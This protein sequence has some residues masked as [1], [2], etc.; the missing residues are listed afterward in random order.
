MTT[1]ASRCARWAAAVACGAVLALAPGP[2]DAAG[3]GGIEVTPLPGVVDGKQVT[4]F[5]VQVGRS[6]ERVQFALRNLTDNTRYAKLYVA[7]ATRAADGSYDVAGPDSTSVV[8]MR[9][10]EVAL[11]PRAFQERSF[12]AAGGLERDAYA[13]VVVEVR[14]GSVVTRAATLVYLSP[15]GDLPIP[16]LL[17]VG[18]AAV[19]LAAGTGV[20]L[21][22]RR[23]GKAEPDRT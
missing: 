17:G 1:A 14:N 18:A 11:P 10:E 7:R 23:R 21:V 9:T 6:G 4:A 12:R 19:A 20:V 8:A 13:A 2:A 3:T 15:D 5:H 22:T 16:L